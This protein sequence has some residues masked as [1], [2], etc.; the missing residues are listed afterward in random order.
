MTDPAARQTL[1]LVEIHNDKKN[2]VF[3]PN[4]CG[5]RQ[6]LQV[7]LIAEAVALL[8]VFMDVIQG[9][10]FWRRL[11]LLSVYVQWIGI[12]SAAVLCLCRESLSRTSPRIVAACSFALLLLVTAAVSYVTHAYA[13][14]T[15][16]AP[17]VGG[18]DLTEFILRNVGLCAVAGGLGLRY[19]WLR[20]EWQRQARAE[21]EARYQVLQ[22]RI[23][24]HFLFNSL[25]SIASLIRSDADRAESAIEDLSELFRTSIGERRLLVSLAEELELTRAYARVEALRLGDRLDIV[26][27]I[28]PETESVPVPPLSL[29]P[30]VENAVY[31]GVAPLPQGGR[32]TVRSRRRDTDQRAWMTMSV[33]NP[34]PSEDE[35]RQGARLALDNIR[36]RLRFVFGDEASLSVRRGRSRFQA[37]VVVP[38]GA[39]AYTARKTSGGGDETG[40]R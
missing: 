34:L 3:L 29:Q 40:D 8:L 14:F 15:G 27:D 24:P 16:I 22:A 30:L 17:L 9:E 4:F 21:A 10:P 6:V 11:F 26:W 19:F 28:A 37:R 33:M 7:L 2:E 35:Q 32:I 31:H 13:P 23:H 25:N 36:E 12:L 1:S 20:A 39:D 38:I 5:S 18:I